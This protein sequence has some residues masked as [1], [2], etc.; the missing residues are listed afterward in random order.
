MSEVKNKIEEE[1]KQ[2]KAIKNIINNLDNDEMEELVIEDLGI[3]REIF[4]I[5]PK[6]LDVLSDALG[7]IARGDAEQRN[8]GINF[9][10]SMERI[11]VIKPGA[12]LEIKDIYYNFKESKIRKVINCDSTSDK[13]APKSFNNF[14]V[15]IPQAKNLTK[16]EVTVL[17]LE[18]M[19]EQKID[20]DDKTLS[21][22]IESVWGEYKEIQES[23]ESESKDNQEGNSNV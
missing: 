8:V 1:V 16:E 6:F 15:S 20:I 19:T 7:A 2:G 18:Q 3:N 17:I 13:Q 21:Y 10:E 22:I 11:K 9:I 14:A 12:S 5:C 23:A 4:G